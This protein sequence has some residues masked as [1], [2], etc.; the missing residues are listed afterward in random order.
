MRVIVGLARN[1]LGPGTEVRK[2]I[3]QN[4]TESTDRFGLEKTSEWK[5]ANGMDAE[6]GPE[7][8][9]AHWIRNWKIE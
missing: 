7:E 6:L 1:V 8:M 9:S 3:E 5:F 4:H 2:G